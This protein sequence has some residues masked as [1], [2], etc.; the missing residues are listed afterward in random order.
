MPDALT[1]RFSGRLPDAA[2][3]ND[4][5]ADFKR[6]IY[7][8]FVE[9]IAEIDR[10]FVQDPHGR[11]E[12]LRQ[13]RREHHLIVVADRIRRS[14]SAS[15]DLSGDALR[16]AAAFVLDR[17][18]HLVAT[19]AKRARPRSHA[20]ENML[21]S[22][23]V[24]WHKLMRSAGSRAEPRGGWSASP[25]R[26][27]GATGVLRKIRNPFLGPQKKGEILREHVH[28][29]LEQLALLAAE[30]MRSDCALSPADRQLIDEVAALA[31]RMRGAQ[32]S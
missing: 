4:H 20:E 29:R 21:T 11:V 28:A 23:R 16:E 12:Q 31:R 15:A 9:A 8:E 25:V 18:D 22:A 26:L 14:P 5:W 3:D 10:A 1:A 27:R 19:G 2:S 24:N 7:G 32:P 13:L 6:A 17:S 30:A